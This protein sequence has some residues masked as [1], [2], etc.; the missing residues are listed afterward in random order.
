MTKILEFSFVPK[1][2]MGETLD[3]LEATCKFYGLRFKKLQ[4]IKGLEQVST[5]PS[6]LCWQIETNDPDEIKT[7][8]EIGFRDT[9]HEEVI[10]G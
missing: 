10:N 2:Q 8:K 6:N 3:E 1:F 9:E 5:D 4:S 7:L